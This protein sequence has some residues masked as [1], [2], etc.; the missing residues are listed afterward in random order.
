MS[1]ALAIVVI[2]WVVVMLLIVKSVVR[3]PADSA[4]VV[5]TLGRVNRVLDPGLHLVVPIVNSISAR[6]SLLEQVLDVPATQGAMRDG[7]P[8][9]VRGTVSLRVSDARRAVAE[10]ADF[11]AAV[12]ALAAREWTAGL[13][14]A[15][16]PDALDAIRAREPAI[17]AAADAFG[18][19]VIRAVPILLL[20][21]EGE[22]DARA[23]RGA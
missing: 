4:Y 6:L 16:P 17:R 7:S 20:D 18:V 23:A 11:R 8:A 1:A 5:S 14:E 9:R 15:D 19:T 10:V 2:G 21:D 22:P 3:V 13:S 12:K